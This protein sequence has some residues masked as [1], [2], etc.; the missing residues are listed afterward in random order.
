V[1]KSLLEY[2]SNSASV[3]PSDVGVFLDET[4]R[5][6]NDVCKVV[7]NLAYEGALHP[8][9]DALLRT[10]QG[11]DFSVGRNLVRAQP[12]VQWIPVNG[13][14]DIEVAAVFE[15]IEGLLSKVTVTDARGITAPLSAAD[16]LVVAPH[17]AH[18]NKLKQAVPEGVRVGTVDLFQGQEAH[19]VIFSMGKLAEGARDVGFLYEVNRINVALSRAR[20]CALVISHEDAVFPPVSSPDDLLLA[21]RF[22]QA[23]QP[24]E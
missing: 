23:V 15:A 8:A 14:G 13:D 10:L 17:N 22:I 6:H 3:L 11:V 5:M 16:I 1:S 4:W 9:G 7:S 24:P 19:A 12:G 21:S 18:V 2:V 20:L